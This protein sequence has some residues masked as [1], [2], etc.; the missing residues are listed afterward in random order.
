VG[1]AAVGTKATHAIK[2]DEGA[3]NLHE[4]GFMSDLQRKTKKS[5]K[6]KD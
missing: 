1:I 6:V 5:G 2:Y 3:M 4:R